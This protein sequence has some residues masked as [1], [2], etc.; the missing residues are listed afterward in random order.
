MPRAREELPTGLQFASPGQNVLRLERGVRGRDCDTRVGT[1]APRLFLP[2]AA[3]QG[4][5]RIP[6]GRK[7][8]GLSA[9]RAAPGRSERLPPSSLAFPKCRR[10]PRSGAGDAGAE[11]RGVQWLGARPLRR[12]TPG[13]AAA[14]LAGPGSLQPLELVSVRAAFLR[15]RRRCCWRRS[16]WQSGGESGRQPPG[17]LPR[18]S[19]PGSRRAQQ[20]GSASRL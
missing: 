17:A 20:R 7:A 10:W 3:S 15:C 19:C 5:L 9:L 18:H 14:A 11:S 2:R 16:S 12:G 4:E 6:L 8:A 1:E 13:S